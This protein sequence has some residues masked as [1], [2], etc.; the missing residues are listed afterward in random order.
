MQKKTYLFDS[1][2]L[3]LLAKITLLRNFAS[4]KDVRITQLIKE[5][6]FQK[7]EAEDS[8]IIEICIKE[9]VIK[10]LGNSDKTKKIAEQFGIDDGE[11]EVIAF[12]MDNN[13]IV[14]TDD[15][16]AIKTCKILNIPF[17]TAIH[18]LISYNKAKKEDKKITLEKLKKL[19][20]IGRYSSEIIKEA[21][22]IIEGEK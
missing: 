5:E 22:M 6:V 2:T 10:L 3:I 13:Y 20:K 21:K 16:K 9:D 4:Q 1:S 12:A 17:I 15:L 14:A 18:C 7:K 8:I 11:A 19:E